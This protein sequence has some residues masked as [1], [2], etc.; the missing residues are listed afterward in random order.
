MS[1]HTGK[2]GSQDGKLGELVNIHFVLKQRITIRWTRRR[3]HMLDTTAHRFAFSIN[4]TSE[5]TPSS[6]ALFERNE[7]WKCTYTL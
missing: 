5:Y 1:P 6:N 2:R 4:F 3:V 7:T